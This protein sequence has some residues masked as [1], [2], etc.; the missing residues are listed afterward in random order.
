MVLVEDEVAVEKGE[1][2]GKMDFTVQY[3]ADCP[4]FRHRYED[5]A[6]ALTSWLLARWRQQHPEAVACGV[7]LA[8][9]RE[10]VMATGA[11]PDCQN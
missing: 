10:A 5:R 4:E 3:G 2:I 1:R 6:N 7:Q 11:D 9:D 8:S